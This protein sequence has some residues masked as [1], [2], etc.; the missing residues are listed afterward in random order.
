MAR[1]GFPG[2]GEMDTPMA[3]RLLHRADLDFSAVVATIREQNS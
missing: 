3:T 2:P 1:I